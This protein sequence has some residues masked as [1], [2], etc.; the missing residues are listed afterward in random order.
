MICLDWSCGEGVDCDVSASV[1][2]DGMAAGSS[3]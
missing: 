2:V 1:V 3:D